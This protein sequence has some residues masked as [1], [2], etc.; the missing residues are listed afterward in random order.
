MYPV[1]DMELHSTVLHHFNCWQWGHVQKWKIETVNIVVSKINF[2][3]TE[4]VYPAFSI[5]WE[6]KKLTI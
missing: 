5:V 1:L 2:I 4:T 6:Y 3:R